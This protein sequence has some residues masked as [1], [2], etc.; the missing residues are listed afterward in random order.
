MNIHTYSNEC[1]EFFDMVEYHLFL[2]YVQA[3]ILI[4]IYVFQNILIKVVKF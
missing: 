3:R 2:D 1:I 4:K